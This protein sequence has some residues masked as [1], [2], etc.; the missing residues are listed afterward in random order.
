MSQVAT[1]RAIRKTEKVLP[2]NQLFISDETLIHFYCVLQQDNQQHFLTLRERN[3][4]SNGLLIAHR[5]LHTLLMNSH[6]NNSQ[7]QNTSI[8]QQ[9][10]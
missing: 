9:F 8:S 1:I 5:E 7:T 10:F 6:Q 3:C 4:S 2:R